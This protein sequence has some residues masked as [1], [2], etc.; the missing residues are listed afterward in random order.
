MQKA[1]R[2]QV[3]GRVQLVMFRDFVQRKASGLGLTG[4]V[5]N[6][7][8][9]TVEVIAEGEHDALEKLLTHLK[10]GPLLARVDNVTVEWVQPTGSFR[11]FS[12]QY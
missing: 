2:A 7:P 1:F 10:S 4:T 9:G 6:L 8:N 3:F 11:G 5:K 12:I